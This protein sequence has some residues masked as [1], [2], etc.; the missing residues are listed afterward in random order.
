MAEV[1]LLSRRVDQAGAER[2]AAALEQILTANTDPGPRWPQIRSLGGSLRQLSRD[3]KQ[4]IDRPA[5][6]PGSSMPEIQP[7]RSIL[8][9]LADTFSR[10]GLLAE[11]YPS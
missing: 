5:V 8:Y 6:L 1:H 3:L 10:L 7:L 2:L 11:D 9:R 4:E